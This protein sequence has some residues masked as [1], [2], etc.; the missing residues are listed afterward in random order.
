LLR[1]LDNQHRNAID[2]RIRTPAQTAHKVSRL[3][4]QIAC[5]R[6]AGKLAYDSSVELRVSHSLHN[7]AYALTPVNG[8]LSTVLLN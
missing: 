8:S 2:D 1:T 7:S 3:K 6:R 4:P 5:A